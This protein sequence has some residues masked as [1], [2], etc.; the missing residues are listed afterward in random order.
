MHFLL[1][2]VCCFGLAASKQV[3]IYNNVAEIKESLNSDGLY[4]FSEKEYNSIIRDSAGVTGLKS[5][6]YI[7][8]SSKLSNAQN[9]IVFYMDPTCSSAN[10][11]TT[12]DCTYLKGI[13][14]DADRNLVQS[15]DNQRFLYVPLSNLQYTSVPDHNRG[16]FK[17]FFNE[18][19]SNK[20]YFSYYS[21]AINWNTEHLLDITTSS[22]IQNQIL[23]TFAII[24]N[25]NDV[26]LR[27]EGLRLVSTPLDLSS[28]IRQRPMPYMAAMVAESAYGGGF[29]GSE[30]IQSEALS[31]LQYNYP[32]TIISIPPYSFMKVTLAESLA[33][34]F[35]YGSLKLY[36]NEGFQK[37]NCD[38][39]IRMAVNKE[40]PEGNLLIRENGITIATS[41]L[42]QTVK[43]KEIDLNL[44]IE[45]TLIY[46]TETS[47]KDTDK[48]GLSKHVL[49]IFKIDNYADFNQN[50]EITITQ[51]LGSISSVN[52]DSNVLRVQEQNPKQIIL[53]GQIIAQ[54]KQV[55]KL[56]YVLTFV[57]PIKSPDRSYY[58]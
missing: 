7:I 53:D 26:T 32:S 5:D 44:G 18:S 9:K 37:G 52:L 34:V 22:Q 39:I 54:G 14:I 49:T 24:N 51:S 20:A 16:I 1:L 4:E 19:P 47:Y 27:S 17:V 33:T 43:G 12:K 8:G 41:K 36:G 55:I 38:K 13:L 21:T 15:V 11:I 40:V 45:P 35:R 31:I 29:A 30:P 25:E 42:G 56:K 10:V 58:T 2:A 3:C 6:Y 23:R 50:I 28:T 57:K 46:K 48:D